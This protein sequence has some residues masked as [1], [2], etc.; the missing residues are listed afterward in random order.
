MPSFRLSNNQADLV[1]KLHR[2]ATGVLGTLCTILR[3]R[4]D[5]KGCKEVMPTYMAVLK[6]YQ[7]MTEGCNRQAQI[8]C[9]EGL[10]YRAYLIRLNLGV[11]LRDKRMTMEAFREIVAYEKKEKALGRYDL[12]GEAPDISGIMEHFVGHDDFN[13][14]PEQDIFRAL[15][16]MNENRGEPATPLS[17]S[18]CGCC[19]KKESMHGDFKKCSRCH[20]QPYCSKKV[21][22]DT[23]LC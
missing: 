21:C 22:L 16:F 18:T 6:N 2:F 1:A 7:K 15:I 12:D 14:V 5:L 17:L 8:D 9:C 13:Q 4:G 20:E 11:Q 19:E 10:T 3:Q 23:T